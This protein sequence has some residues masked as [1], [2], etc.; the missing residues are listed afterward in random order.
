[1]RPYAFRPAFFRR[2]RVSDF[3]D[4]WRVMS[5][6]SETLEPRRPAVV[7]LYFLTGMAS[8]SLRFEDLDGIP[9]GQGDHGPLLVGALAGVQPGPLD[10]PLAGQ[11]VHPEDP[12]VPDLLDG[13]LDLGLVG[14]RRHEERVRVPL[15]PGV[16]LLRDDGPD[17][18]VAGALHRSSPAS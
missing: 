1:M 12:D 3:S 4:P 2:A 13:F 17:D 11:G 16:G 15:Q 10:L 18:H 8:G 7:G 6:K 9:R 14:V 5:E